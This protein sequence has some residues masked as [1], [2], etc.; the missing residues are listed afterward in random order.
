MNELEKIQKYIRKTGVTYPLTSPYHLNLMELSALR[1]M[2]DAS[3][4][5]CLAFEYG[6]AKGERSARAAQR[7]GAT[8]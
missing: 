7:K 1:H 8:A 5:I 2:G 6:R 3:K 4:A